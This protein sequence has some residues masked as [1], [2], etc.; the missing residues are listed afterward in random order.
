MSNYDSK[1]EYTQF[2]DKSDEQNIES[3][4]M[5]LSVDDDYDESQPFLNSHERYLTE[6]KKFSTVE[7]GDDHFRESW[8]LG[9]FSK[10]ENLYS[11]IN[12]DIEDTMDIMRNN[13][14]RITE[15]ERDTQLENMDQKSENLLDG[16]IKFSNESKKLKIQ[17]WT[18][19]TCN[20]IAISISTALIITLFAIL[21][22][23]HH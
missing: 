16:T 15:T 17:M 9:Q 8:K 2:E 4:S 7:L 6:S 18:K 1:I 3:P 20:F 5:Y 10:N 11:E 23:R 21:G 12:N 19:H 14:N 13:I 22:R